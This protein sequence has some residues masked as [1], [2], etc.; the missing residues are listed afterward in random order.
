MA[1]EKNG[2]APSMPANNS[3]GARMSNRRTIEAPAVFSARVAWLARIALGF[4]ILTLAACHHDGEDS[5]GQSSSGGAAPTGLSYSNPVSAVAGTMM[6]ALSPTVSGTVTSYS[7][8][9]ALPAGLLLDTTSGVISGTPSAAAA[10]ATYTVTA[11]NASGSTTFGLSLT[12]NPAAPTALS[13]SSPVQ[14]TVGVAAA[15]LTP[16]VTGTVASYTVSPALPAGLSLDASGAISGTPTAAAAQ[17]NYTIT[18]ANVSG[19]VSFQLSLTVNAATAPITPQPASF[20]PDST[21]SRIHAALLQGQIDLPTSLMYRAWAVFLDPQLPPQY[22]AAG[23]GTEDPGL[24]EEI[25]SVWSTLPAAAQAAIQPYLLRPTDPGSPFTTGSAAASPARRA[26]AVNHRQVADAG[27]IPQCQNWVWTFATL[28][29][30]KVWTCHTTDAEDQ[31]VFAAVTGIFDRHWD[32]MTLDMGEPRRDDGHG[33]DDSVDVYVIDLGDCLKRSGTCTQIGPL[34]SPFAPYALCMP[35]DAAAGAPGGQSAYMLL[36]KDRALKNDVPFEADVVH[37]F[38]HALQFAHVKNSTRI[39]HLD[40]G[41]T[42]FDQSW[43]VEASAKWAEWAYVPASTLTG[44]HPWYPA[45]ND[46]GYSDS[47]YQPGMISLLLTAATQHPYAS[48]IW[49]YFMQQESHG[50][51]VVSDAWFGAEFADGP[52]KINESINTQ[53][54]F[55]DNFGEFMVRNL[56][57]LFPGDPLK[58]HFWDMDTQFPQD[59]THPIITDR[60]QFPD[61]LIAFPV[62]RRLPFEIPYLAAN[63]V[64]VKVPAYSGVSHLLFSLDTDPNDI[65]FESVGELMGAT[66]SDSTW[67]RFTA[68]NTTLE[69]CLTDPTQNVDQLILMLG[70]PLFSLSSNAFVPPTVNGTLSITADNDC[71]EW[72]GSIK[73]VY[74]VL[75][76]T[77]TPDEQGTEI[78]QSHE[79]TTETWTIEGAQPDPNFPGY[80]QL[81]FNWI[82][83]DAV[84]DTYDL[85][86]NKS[87]GQSTRHTSISGHDSLTGTLTYDVMS[88]PNGG[89]MLGNPPST[90]TPPDPTKT[91]TPAYDQVSCDGTE[92][93]DDSSPRTISNQLP[94]ALTTLPGASLMTDPNDLTHFVGSNTYTVAPGITDTVS[95][96]IRHRAK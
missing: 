86:A 45:A 28:G 73:S 3:T 75:V 48:Y 76:H 83:A 67:K 35:A 87:C 63:Y 47:N 74:K 41:F 2:A 81:K 65:T 13:Y 37:E 71:G 58:T 66:A 54:S 84:D 50:P 36:R 7:V 55:A 26:A 6:T 96:D 42:D 15:S 72:S 32:V 56:N 85:W 5:G 4:A 34:G 89:I 8:T 40:N 92:I 51:E 10:G 60:E 77:E 33:G 49:P 94:F 88:G 43:F 53:F 79:I 70:S 20:T 11:T 14:L 95:Y 27:Q 29:F 68:N 91:W 62:Q 17:A 46:A 16:T 1:A 78:T 22:D 69:F 93:T 61:I 9:P 21:R 31:A 80:V 64:N 25:Q 57:Y 44:V 23:E 82:A 52:D 18:A 30:I 39:V 19:S 24:F 90:T 59:A 12:V 38:F